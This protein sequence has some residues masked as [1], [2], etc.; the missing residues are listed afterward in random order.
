MKSYKTRYNEMLK[1]YEELKESTNC[2]DMS[3][4]EETVKYNLVKRVEFY[5]IGSLYVRVDYLNGEYIVTFKDDKSR[6]YKSRYI[7]D[8]YFTILHMYYEHGRYYRRK[9][10]VGKLKKPGK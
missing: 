8:V 4:M 6:E 2:F 5:N 3:R 10:K 9:V 7:E 1:Q